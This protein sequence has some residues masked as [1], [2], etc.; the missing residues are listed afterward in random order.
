[1]SRMTTQNKSI[2][3]NEAGINFLHR[4]FGDFKLLCIFY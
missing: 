2:P 3:S 1:M 4:T